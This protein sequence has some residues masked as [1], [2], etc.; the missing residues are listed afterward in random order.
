[1][2]Q[3]YDYIIVGQG[4]AGTCLT[5]SLQEQGKKV[6]VIS[7]TEKPSASMIAGGLFNP[8]TG[9]KMVLTWMAAELFPF[10]HGYYSELEKKLATRFVLNSALYRP[11]LS[12]EEQNKWQ[13]KVADEIYK[14]FVRQVCTKGVPDLPVNNAYG[15]LELMQSGAIRTRIFLEAFR[16]Y[17]ISEN[18]YINE[19]FD[20]SELN[21][22]GENVVYKQYACTKIIFAE[23]P[24]VENNPWF[25]NVNINRLKGEVLEIR[26]SRPIDRIVS[27]G[28]FVLPLMDTDN[29]CI[30]GSTY[31]HN[32]FSWEPSEKGR[33]EIEN[34]LAQLLTC[35]YEVISQRA[36]LRPTVVDRRPVMGEHPNNAKLAIFNGLGTKGVSLAPYFSAHFASHLTSNTLLLPEVDVNRFTL[37]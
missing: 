21:L 12:I 11:F 19:D 33:K 3:E 15:G 31:E 2:Y 1:M 23:G 36:G 5:H 25:K 29:T 4:L 20:Y 35:G 32:N 8:V 27:R 22:E 26:T 30:V 28:I 13:G 24:A 16:K 34:K 6:L 18:S 10:L 9:R 37:D 14:P 7:N 17:L